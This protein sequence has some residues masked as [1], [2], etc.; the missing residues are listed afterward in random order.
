[1]K[2]KTSAIKDILIIEPELFNDERGYFFESYNKKELEKFGITGEFMQDSQ[3]QSKKGVLRGMHFQKEPFA[4]GKL[5]RVVRGAVLDVIV[6]LRKNSPSFGKWLSMELNE[7]N[8]K[9]LWIPPGFAHGFLCTEDNT[10]F[11]Y[12][13]T[14]FYNKQAELGFMWND[15][16]LNI[17]WELEKYG[18]KEPLL[19]GKDKLL[20]SFDKIDK[21]SLF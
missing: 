12:K 8:K 14:N 4:Q 15:A 7:K 19:S 11:S 16:L 3:S 17:N 18:I 21:E 1:M 10:I 9:M 20:P 13:C 5:I 2:I 6:D